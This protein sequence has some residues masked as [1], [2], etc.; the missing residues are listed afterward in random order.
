MNAEA[1]SSNFRALPL[2]LDQTCLRLRV[3]KLDS[4]DATDVVE[5]ACVLVVGDTLWEPSLDDEVAGL[6]IQILLQIAPDNDVHCGCLA[7]LI[8]VQAAVFVRLEHGWS[9]LDQHLLL[10]VS[11]S[12]EV[13]GLGG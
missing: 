4:L 11:D 10:L 7:N 2:T 13:D 3:L 1:N 12:D 6:L 9:D 8:L 5:I